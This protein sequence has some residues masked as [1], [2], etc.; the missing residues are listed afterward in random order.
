MSNKAGAYSGYVYLAPSG[1]WSWTIYLG[2]EE[3]CAGAGYENVDDARAGCGEVLFDYD[4]NAQ[5][6]A[7]PPVPPSRN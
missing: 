3:C 7:I 2:S 4:E 5:F 1:Q 6:V